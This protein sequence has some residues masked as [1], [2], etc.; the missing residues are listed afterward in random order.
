M[1][2]SIAMA[3]FAAA[4]PSQATA[5]PPRAAAASAAADTRG[6]LW[7]RSFLGLLVTQF[8]VSLNDNMFRWLIV[9]IGMDLLGAEHA[10]RALSLGLACLVLPYIFLAAPAGYLADRFS[11]RTV[12]IGCKVAEVVLVI[13]GVA[14]ILQGNIYLMFG[15]LTLMG[16]QAALFSP[17]KMSSVPEIVRA[18]RL[19]AANGLIGLTTILAVIGGT[20]A[21]GVL[22][23]LTGT[24]GVE[25][26][27]ISAAALISVAL[28]GLA[29]SLCIAPLQPANPS[30]RFP[31]H[32]ARQT[33]RDLAALAAH[34]PLLLAASASAF[35]WFLAAVSQ[36]NVERLATV[37]LGMKQEYVGPLLA[38]L[39]VGVGLGSVL[40]GIW[41]AGKIELGMVPWAAAGMA[42]SCTLLYFVPAA[43]GNPRSAG[44]IW[45][46]LGLLALGFSAGFFDV[47]LQA[48]LQHR[49]PPQS[50]GAILAAYNFI[51]FS[52]MLLAAALFWF[53]S[54]HLRLSARQIFLLGGLATLPVFLLSARL[55]ALEALRFAVWLLTRL[56]YR[57]RVEGLENVPESGGAMLVSNHV[58]WADGILLGLACPR[59]VRMIAYGPYFQGWWIR[60]FARAAGIIP[61]QPG[62]SSVLH[63]V[64]T[65]KEALLRGD[66]VCIFPEG[67]LT[68]TGQMQEF[69]PGFLSMMKG[70][71]APVVPV[72]LGGL[73]GSIFSFGGGRF[74]W[75][76][77]R[78]LPYPVTILFGRP[79]PRPADVAPVRQAVGQL[80]TQAMQQRPSYEMNLPRKFLRTC[81]GAMLRSKVADSSGADLTGA[82]LLIGTLVLRRVLRRE[83]L[84][85][86]EEQVGLLLPPS[87]GSVLANT[88][89]GI[90][91]RIAVNLNYTV[92]A[93]VMN[94]CIA[95][96][97]I[98]HVL[99][100]PRL[101]ERFP[102]KIDAEVVFLEDL[103]KKITRADKLIAAAQA[104]LL[105]AAVLERWLGLTRIKMDD[106]LTVMF[107]SGSTG[108]P[109]GVMLTHR[110]V[111]SNVEA[112]DEIVHLV[113]QDVLVGV[114]PMFHSFGYT[115]TLWT[116]LTLAPK[117]VY[118]YTPLEPRQIGKLCRQHGATILV[119]TPTFLRSYLRRCEPED[120]A[121]LDV[122]FTGAEK[123][124]PELAEAFEK[125]FGVR[126]VEGYGAT[127][128]SP[129]VSGNIPPSRD[130]TGQ[131]GIREGTVGR[132]LPGIA[133]KVVD[134]DSGADLGA[135][136]P[137]LLLVTGPNVM[138]GYLGRPDLTAQAIREGWYLTGDVARIDADGFIHITD[139]LSRFS[140]IGGEM[141]PHIRIEE[142]IR[143]L[144]QL[145]E[146]ELRLAV[147]A[148]PD[149]KK[150][151]RLVVLHTALPLSGEELCRRLAQSGLPPIW[152]PSPD[153]FRQVEAIPL[154]GTG[155]LDLKRLKDLALEEFSVPHA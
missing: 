36:V 130:L 15:V 7:T 84:D 38:A 154:L 12:I 50:R 41:S 39:A 145:D 22:Y 106:L 11:K 65:T 113:P 105:P 75:K 52:G 8:L 120:F 140:K 107:T 108:Q 90:D 74:F 55:L 96:C 103:R 29:A 18:D 40:A 109:K 24:R 37:T 86:R 88:A 121:T 16:A 78:R 151:E 3:K 68:R 124:S 83:V 61:I 133:A 66:L 136:Q 135:D 14:S 147:A 35:Y 20:V 45:S 17:A 101:L 54:E 126:P 58:S 21:G 73:W 155:K 69:R 102:L 89:L 116:A 93:D 112:V 148:V 111:G 153:S 110:N 127:E 138:K 99:T 25:H 92:S 51:T 98:R 13:L 2:S 71:D 46:C 42:V 56:V 62:A 60:W 118:H 149:V 95:Q 117:A 4:G 27:W 26:W 77:P 47:P 114:L 33:V 141:V 144:L 139:R 31:F 1:T 28:L 79:L 23:A 142:A 122:V 9:P 119:T 115:T 91:R 70:T 150:G 143:D 85:R 152:I 94:Q 137:G 123:L 134:P 132:P 48:F 19:S 67:G 59:R 131:Q 125:R 43:A 72:Y 76:W 6:G 104:W 44:F 64:R 97:G 53:L 30:R 57:V 63:S 5:V 82:K 81:R 129:V 128:L 146:D 32:A 34:R 87:V 49:S 100:S 10:N 80:G